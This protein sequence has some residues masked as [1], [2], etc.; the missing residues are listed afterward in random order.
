MKYSDVNSL[1]WANAEQTLIDCVITFDH[2]GEPLPF[3]ANAN[4]S[5]AHGR[6]I[7]AR[8]IAGDFGEIAAY[9]APSADVVAEQ[10]RAQ[11]N[12]LLAATDWS[13]LPDVPQSIKDFWA[14]YRQA[15]RDVTSQAD[16]PNDVVWPVAPV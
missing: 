8:C 12:Q 7:F 10:V 14:P 2:I 15:L 6:E 5:A 9:V 16:F 4:D 1:Q 3:T 13:Q 11:R